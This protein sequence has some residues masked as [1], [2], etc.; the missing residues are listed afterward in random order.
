MQT[1]AP[2]SEE[3]VKNGECG[4]KIIPQNA[5][6]PPPGHYIFEFTDKKEHV[7]KDGNYRQHYP[8]LPKKLKMVVYLA[9]LRNLIHANNRI[10]AKNVM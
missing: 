8:D 1:N 5:K 2:L 9:V 4:G 6:D 10:C 3:Q 7:D